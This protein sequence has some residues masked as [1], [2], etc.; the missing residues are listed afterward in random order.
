MQQIQHPD[1]SESLRDDVR[2]DAAP[3]AF[4]HWGDLGGNVVQLRQRVYH[5]ENVGEFEHL[6]VPEEHP[7]PNTCVAQHVVRDVLHHFVGLGVGVFGRGPEVV[8]PGE[9]EELLGEEEG[10]DEVGL[11]AEEGEVRVVDF[12]H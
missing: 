2:E 4:V 7:S 1:P 5:D 6:R 3:A 10:G 12:F 8:E 9:L 11:G